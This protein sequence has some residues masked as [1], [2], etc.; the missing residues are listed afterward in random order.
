M[1]V[2]IFFTHTDRKKGRNG[3]NP[4]LP[5][6]TED[7]DRSDVFYHSRAEG[8]GDAAALK[9]PRRLHSAR[10][11]RGTATKAEESKVSDRELD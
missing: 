2:D 5:G 10:G 8:R 3:Q 7:M 1:I 4:K 6:R 11:S 9:G